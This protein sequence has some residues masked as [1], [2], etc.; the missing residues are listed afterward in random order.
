MNVLDEKTGKVVTT[1]VDVKL[2]ENV[3]MK[4]EML[5]DVMDLSD[6]QTKMIIETLLKGGSV[7]VCEL[8]GES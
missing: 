3:M 4:V 2:L 1:N 6:E 8:M 7:D 5:R